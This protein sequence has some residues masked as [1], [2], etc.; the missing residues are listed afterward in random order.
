MSAFIRA[1]EQK[2]LAAGVRI[3][4]SQPVSDISKAGGHYVLTTAGYQVHAD[5]LVIAVDAEGMKYI[6]GEIADKIKA[7]PQF[8]DITGIKV[9]TVTQW[10]PDAWWQNAQPGKDIRRAWTTESCVNALEIPI[11]PYAANQ[12]VMRS[13]Y[14]DDLQCV[15]FWE[16]T[17]QRGGTAAVEAE[18]KRGFGYLFPGVNIPNPLKTYVQIWPA[19]WHF[20]RAGSP[21]NNMDIATWAIQ[22]IAGELV[23][24]VGESYNPQR[25]GWTDGAYK[26]SINTLNTL[27]GMN[28]PGQT[29]NLVG[30][31]A[32]IAPVSKGKAPVKSHSPRH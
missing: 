6:G 29:A 2:A 31:L 4:Y 7:Q 28:L 26:S 17:Y 1:M 14:V 30:P 10:Y 27:Y 12:K 8:Q 32:P 18:I 23:S 16:Q 3:Y 13:V 25:S 5:R 20:V 19:G 15:N 11:N 22:P 21:F 24:L 9:A